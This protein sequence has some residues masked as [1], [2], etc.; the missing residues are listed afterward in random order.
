MVDQVCL[1]H[2]GHRVHLLGETA[3]ADDPPNPEDHCNRQLSGLEQLHPVATQLRDQSVPH[4][5]VVLGYHARVGQ[6]SRIVKLRQYIFRPGR[7]C[8]HI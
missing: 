5:F 1:G 4:A 6:K 2:H 3:R 8:V 7:R